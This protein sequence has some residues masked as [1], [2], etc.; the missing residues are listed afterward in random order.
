MKQYVIDELRLGD[1]SKLVSYLGE[2]LGA[3]RVSG[4]YKLPLSSENLSD[5][6]S[7]HIRCRPFYFAIDLGP[8]RMA[9]EFLVR[10]DQRARCD[11][12]GYATEQQRNWLIRFADTMLSRLEIT[13]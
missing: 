2:K 9:C 6:Q 4:L 10:T 1:Y 11:C 7:A 3:P 12:V 13:V 8:D 5:T